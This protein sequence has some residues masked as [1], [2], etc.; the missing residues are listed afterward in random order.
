MAENMKIRS[1][2]DGICKTALQARCFSLKF[3]V[4]LPIDVA[5]GLFQPILQ[6]VECCRTNEFLPQVTEG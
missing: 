2:A 6:T 3:F 4:C 5:D 1:A